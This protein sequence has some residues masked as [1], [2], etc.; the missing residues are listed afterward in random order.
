MMT[1]RAAVSDVP[2]LVELARQEHAMSKMADTPFDEDVCTE[3]FTAAIRGL[4]SVVF[5][6]ERDGKPS[7]LIAGSMQPNLHN[8]YGTVYELL[9]FAVDGSGMRLLRALQQWANDMRA[10][11][12]VVHNYAGVVACERFDKAMT[13]FGFAPLGSSYVAKLEN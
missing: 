8:R 2:G 7:G 9:W 1:R 6:T 12:M 11:S 10:T 13:R 5:V 4:S 3:R